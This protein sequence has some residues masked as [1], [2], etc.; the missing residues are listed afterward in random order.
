MT[1]LLITLIVLV[2]ALFIY[3]NDNRLRKLVVPRVNELVGRDVQID[4]ISFTL[5]RTFPNFGL[6]MNGF[7][8]PDEGD[9]HIVRFDEMLLSVKLIPLLRSEVVVSRLDVTNPD[10][11]YIVYED[12]SKNLDF[13]FEDGEPADPEATESDMVIDLNE[14]RVTGGNILYDDRESNMVA[15]LNGLNMTMSLR[16]AEFIETDV[17]ARLAGLSFSLDGTNY[18]SNL[19]L[20][21]RQTSELDLAGEVLRLKEGVFSVRG[22]AMDLS[23][24]VRNWSQ[25]VMSLDIS[26]ASS[27]DNF[28]SLLELVPDDYLEYV[29]GIQT[30]GQFMVSGYIRGDLGYEIIPDFNFEI[31]VSDGFMRHPQASKPVESV[32]ISLKANNSVVQIERFSALA[33]GNR[34]S[35]TGSVDDPIGDNAQFSLDGSLNLDLSTIEAFFP[36]SEFG[37]ELKGLA[38]V[39]ARATGKVADPEN[40]RFN[41]NVTLNKGYIRYLELP[42]AMEDIEIALNATQDVV[43]IQSF[44]ARA[45][46]NRLNLSGRINHPL[47]E[48]RIAFDLKADA[49]LDLATIK[50]F[51][52]IDEDTLTMR[53]LFVF[54]GTARGTVNNPDQSVINGALTLQNGFI[55][56]RDIPKPIENIT[57]DSRLTANEFQIRNAS[58][59]SGTNTVE[60]NGRIR[61]YMRGTPN[62]DLKFKASVNLDEI[63]EFYSLEE[64]MI[65]ITGK[66]TAD[67]ALRGPIDDFDKILFSGGVQLSNVSIVGDS[68]PQPITN[69][70]GNLTFTERDVNLQRFTMKMG[71]SDFD[72]NGDLVNWRALMEDPGGRVS[73]ANLTAN[74]RSRMLN[75]DEIV[76]W[77]EESDDPVYIELPNLRSTLTARIDT[78]LIMGIRI[79]EIRGEGTTDPKHL[80]M[81]SA[82]ARL[83]DG[84][85]AGQLKW[86]I[87]QKDYTN[88][89]FKGNLN[90]VRAEAFFKEFQMGVPGNFH[91]HVSGGFSAETDYKSDMDAFFTQVTPT[92]KADGTFGLDR[93]RLRGH[94]TQVA[95]ADLLGISELRDMSMD[96]WTATYAIS[97]GILTLTD[98]NLTSQ[99]IGLT[100]NGNQNLV[101]DRLNYKLQLRFPTRYSD[102]IARLISEQAVKAITTED[103][104]I[105]LPLLLVG[106][107]ERPRVTID[108]DLVEEILKEYLVNQGTNLVEDAA[109]RLLRGI[110]GN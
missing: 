21:L 56:H 39:D 42:Q 84:T 83:F 29:E 27:S 10:V 88:I 107:S 18:I 24:E 65:A 6:T 94:P 53:G 72:L 68:I 101:E 49:S 36:V 73:P 66:A 103:G 7:S 78:M 2:S 110:R 52:P 57:L 85:A 71:S 14:V 55:S 15:R 89:E 46:R 61:N 3:L 98:M 93:A 91:K 59:R 26:L 92:I 64:F 50:E 20:S 33:D 47:D 32:Q 9:T 48:N 8:L 17:D 109:R 74:Y 86:T 43:N 51:Y 81:S 35:F 12:G 25:D 102:Q 44:Q 11:R 60:G 105:V 37:V 30:S 79:T 22:L 28:G 97:D 87:T 80:Q 95:I 13:L 34:L 82:S 62:L 100:V 77:E 4:R 1:G 106:S 45:S 40:A 23:G 5:F 69:M 67:L 104:I 19:G 31:D 99:D 38:T 75:V 90:N 76:D 58:L 108:R 54:D 70:N 16:F 63:E 96:S 41:A